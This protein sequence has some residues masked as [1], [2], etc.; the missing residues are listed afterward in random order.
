LSYIFQKRTDKPTREVGDTISLVLCVIVSDSQTH[1]GWPGYL[2]ESPASKSSCMGE[3]RAGG[4]KGQKHPEAQISEKH[5]GCT[6]LMALWI[7]GNPYIMQM[8]INNHYVGSKQ[9]DC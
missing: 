3:G 4:G 7:Q 5:V 6:L 8:P 9:R 2:D 1:Q